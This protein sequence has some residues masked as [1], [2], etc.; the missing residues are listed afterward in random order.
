MWIGESEVQRSEMLAVSGG[1]PPRD[2]SVYTAWRETADPAN[3][4]L[5]GTY[6]SYLVGQFAGMGDALNLSA[7]QSAMDILD[8]EREERPEMARRLVFLHG[9]VRDAQKVAK[10]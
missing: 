8:V 9:L 6:S 10:G 3:L 2:L 7:V 4:G 5:I 1:A